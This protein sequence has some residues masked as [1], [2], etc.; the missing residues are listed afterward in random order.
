[1]APLGTMQGNQGFEQNGSSSV[2][3]FGLS[4]KLSIT[5]FSEDLDELGAVRSRDNSHS[6]QC[7][8]VEHEFPSCFNDVL[9]FKSTSCDFFSGGGGEKKDDNETSDMEL[10]TEEIEPEAKEKDEQWTLK[11]ELDRDCISSDEDKGTTITILNKAENSSIQQRQQ[12]EDASSSILFPH[13]CARDEEKKEDSDDDRDGGE[14]KNTNQSCSAMN[15]KLING[16]ESF[17]NNS[18]VSNLGELHLH[19]NKDINDECM[20][21]LFTAIGEICKNLQVLRLSHTNIS[22]QTCKSILHFFEKYFEDCNLCEI[23]LQN[24]TN[25]NESGI[26]ELNKIFLQNVLPKKL[27]QKFNDSSQRLNED[28][29]FSFPDSNQQRPL[30]YQRND[31]TL[32]THNIRRLTFTN[33]SS[34]LSPRFDNSYDIGTTSRKNN[35]LS[36]P[37]SIESN[38][39][40]GNERNDRN[41][42]GNKIDDKNK[43]DWFKIDITGCGHKHRVP[44]WDPRI[45]GGFLQ[46]METK[47]KQIE[48]AKQNVVVHNLCVSRANSEIRNILLFNKAAI[49]FIARKYYWLESQIKST[50]FYFFLTIKIIHIKHNLYLFRSNR[51]NNSKLQCLKKNFLKRTQETI[52]NFKL[53][54]TLLKRNFIPFN[55]LLCFR[56]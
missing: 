41:A 26:H 31:Y 20:T 28:K 54:V 11:L 55:T 33:D 29:A 7:Y 22:N 27:V 12:S 38:F 4:E 10:D 42:T 47:T 6:N 17:G 40:M 35:T 21:I 50:K 37:M 24:N 5:L 30:D 8:L 53:I 2:V 52:S 32:G 39:F 19:W 49:I 43:D 36:S 56:C 23:Y 16:I 9:L 15:T 45:I 34:L 51:E 44:E 1:M 13:A 48:Q 14:Q 25:I 3:P 46:Q 18:F